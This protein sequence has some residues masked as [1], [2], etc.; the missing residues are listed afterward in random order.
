VYSKSM[1]LSV[2][3]LAMSQSKMVHGRCDRK[4]STILHV[5]LKPWRKWGV[6]ASPLPINQL[7][8]TSQG[9][10]KMESCTTLEVETSKNKLM[11]GTPHC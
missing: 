1:H 4:R 5:V 3:V 7:N 2:T 6:K 11:D 10:R 9:F 8:E